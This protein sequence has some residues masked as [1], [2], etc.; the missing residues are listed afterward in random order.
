MLMRIIIGDDD[1]G[2]GDDGGEGGTVFRCK[3]AMSG[4]VSPKSKANNLF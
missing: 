2:K 4:N 3:R 1:D